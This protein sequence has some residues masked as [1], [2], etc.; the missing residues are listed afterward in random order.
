L[1][2]LVKQ[3]LRYHQETLFFLLLIVFFAATGFSWIWRN[4]SESLA[5]HSHPLRVEKAQ[6]DGGVFVRSS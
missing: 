1:G 4:V 6:K 5:T 3:K 2:T